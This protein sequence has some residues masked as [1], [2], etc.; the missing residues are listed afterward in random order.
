MANLPLHPFMV[1]FPIA[2]FFFESFLLF[3][4]RDR[5]D[6]RY[7]GMA[8]LTFK[9]A[10]FMMIL[11]LG[12]GLYDAGGIPEALKHARNHFFSAL[13]FAGYQTFRFFY[14]SRHERYYFGWH[15][16][17]SLIGIALV[18]VTGYFGGRLVYD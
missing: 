8:K 18:L 5:Q 17:L 4:A 2:L 1:H 9:V 12:A 13:S 7:Q 14:W 15:L 11:A 6:D 10:F 3:I 16:L